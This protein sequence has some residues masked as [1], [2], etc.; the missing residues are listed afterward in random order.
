MGESVLKGRGVRLE[1][2]LGAFHRGLTNIL[3]HCTL[4]QDVQRQELT[5]VPA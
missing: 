5:G 4:D 2:P 3:T 1:E